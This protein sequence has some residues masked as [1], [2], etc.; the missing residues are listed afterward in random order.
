[1]TAL[2]GQVIAA[3]RG[4]ERRRHASAERRYHLAVLGNEGPARARAVVERVVDEVMLALVADLDGCAIVTAGDDG[5]LGR[6]P[7]EVRCGT[8]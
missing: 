8:G 4:P 2:T 7:V 5:P 1:M 3:R 6:P